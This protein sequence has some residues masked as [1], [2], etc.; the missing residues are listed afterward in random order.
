MSEHAECV[1]WEKY[2]IWIDTPCNCDPDPRSVDA[3][4]ASDGS[5][6]DANTD[7]GGAATDASPGTD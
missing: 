4:T 2:G 7:D 3:D 6:D 1:C 5:I